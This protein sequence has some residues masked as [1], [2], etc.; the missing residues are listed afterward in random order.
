M[1]TRPAPLVSAVIPTLNRPRLLE[2]AISS[3]LAQ[4]LRAIEVIVVIDGPDDAT[5]RTLNNHPD[6]RLRVLALPA[7]VGAAQARNLGIQA[8]SAEWIALLDDD[9]EWEASK[10]EQQLSAAERSIF[11]QPIVVCQYYLPTPQGVRVEP[12]RFPRPLESIGDYLLARESWLAEDR[13]LMSS[14]LFARRAL[15]LRFPFQAGMQRHQ[16]WDWLLRV[17]AMAEVGFAGIERPLATYHF[18]EARPHLSSSMRWRDSLAWAN[19][20]RRAGRLSDQAY[21]GFVVFHV[22]NFAA[23][24]RSLSALRLTSAAVFSARPR[25]FQVARH[26]ATWMFTQRARRRLRLM[27]DKLL[28]LRPASH[29]KPK[30]G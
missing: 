12:V 18:H 27:A 15:F 19:E 6:A 21:V 30:A 10:L 26:V 20:H 23:E 11:V 17:S 7:N 29:A 9:D 3:A 13:T 4:T 28:A 22:V 14:I 24:E 2:R 1:N 8:A 25:P 16:D 5:R